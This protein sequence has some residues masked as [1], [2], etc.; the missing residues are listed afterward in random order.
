MIDFAFSSCYN[1]ITPVEINFQ[2]E[3]K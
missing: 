3:H 1:E 2:E